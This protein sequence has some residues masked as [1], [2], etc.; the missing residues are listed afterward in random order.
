MR[1]PIT[2]LHISDMQFGHNY[3][4]G[5]LGLPSP[6]DHFD[7]LIER[8]QSDLRTSPATSQIG[9][10]SR[11]STM[12][13]K[14]IEQL[15]SFLKLKRNQVVIIPGNHDI[16][17]K[18]CEAYFN[19]CE[20][21]DQRRL[22]PYWPKWKHYHAFFQNSYKD[23]P[24]ITFTRENPWASDPGVTSEIVYGGSERPSEDIMRQ[25]EKR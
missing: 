14:F 15:T 4:F 8:L 12:H 23:E 19:E 20:A 1:S 18:A 17:R 5:R 25:A 24:T 11:N 16:N 10:R 21:D 7:S 22:S 6:D 9:A 3:R 13:L 2:L